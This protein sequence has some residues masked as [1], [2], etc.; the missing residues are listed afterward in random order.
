MEKFNDKCTQCGCSKG[1]AYAVQEQGLEIH[2]YQWLKSFCAIRHFCCRLVDNQPESQFDYEQIVSYIQRN[3]SR[4]INVE[5]I[6]ADTKQEL[7]DKLIDRLYTY[8]ECFEWEDVPEFKEGSDSDDFKME[9]YEVT[10]VYGQLENGMELDD[11][12]LIGINT[13]GT[14]SVG[15]DIVICTTDGEQHEARVEWIEKREVQVDEASCGDTIGIGID[16]LIPGGII[17]CIYKSDEF[18]DEIGELTPEE[19]EYV[20]EYEEI[21]SEGE[22]SPRDQRYLD[23][24]REVYDISDE[25]AEKL[26]AMVEE[27]I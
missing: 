21:I 2:Q 20:D 14:I 6:E 25:R 27:N 22:I 7:Y 1:I 15:E 5:D 10:K 19:Q 8:S 24:L 12:V 26:E 4:T 16:T 17:D 11:D 18:Y 9:V 23:K 3:L 13:S